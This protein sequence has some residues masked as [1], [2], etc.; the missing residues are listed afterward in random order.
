ME[1]HK[2]IIKNW[3]ISIIELKNDKTFYKVTKRVPQLEVCETKM[4]ENYN[5]AK[6]QLQ[7]WLK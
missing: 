4:F 7:K 6:E 1:N 5:K 3:E 2:H